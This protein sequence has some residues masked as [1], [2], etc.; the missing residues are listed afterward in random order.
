[1]VVALGVWFATSGGSPRQPAE[2]QASPVKF[3]SPIVT[4]KEPVS[5][6]DI[7]DI[8][9]IPGKGKGMVARRDIKVS[10]LARDLVTMGNLNVLYS[11]G[12]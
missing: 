9:D 5:T 6:S 12:I 10:S 8:V 2:P 3:N 11:K 1:M 4:K 7:Y